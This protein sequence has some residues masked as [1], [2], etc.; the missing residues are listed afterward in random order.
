[1]IQITARDLH[2]ALLANPELDAFVVLYEGEGSIELSTQTTME[3]SDAG[4][5]AFALVKA[6]RI[7]FWSSQGDAPLW[8]VS[9]KT[10]IK[11]AVGEEPCRASEDD[12]VVDVTTITVTR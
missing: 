6:A 1:M 5:V 4:D 9:N 10:W 2:A 8:V 12:T 3:E 7:D 11:L